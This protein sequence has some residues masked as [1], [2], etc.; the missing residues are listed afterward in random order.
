M[1]GGM[2]GTGTATFALGVGDTC[3]LQDEQ[4][5]HTAPGGSEMKGAGHGVYRFSDDG[6]SVTAWWIDNHAPE[7]VK[8][9]GDLKEDGFDISGEDANGKPFRIVLAKTS[10]G[11]EVR[12]FMG[13]SKEPFWTQTYEKASPAR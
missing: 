11:F 7:M 13:D 12:S 4:A 10:T 6:S 9:S 2:T 5:T 1:T 3:L 8:T